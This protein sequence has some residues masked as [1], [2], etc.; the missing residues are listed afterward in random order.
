MNLCLGPP[1]ERDPE[2]TIYTN[3]VDDD[4]SEGR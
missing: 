2:T 4:E 1:A 3:G